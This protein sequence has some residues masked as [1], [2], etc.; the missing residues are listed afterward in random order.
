[1]FGPPEEVLVTEASSGA[2]MSTRGNDHFLLVEVA[3]ALLASWWTPRTGAAPMNAS[4]SRLVSVSRS[5]GH[6]IHSFCATLIIPPPQTLLPS[7]IP[8][9]CWM[10]PILEIRVFGLG[11]KTG[12]SFV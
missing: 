2:R 1:M 6:G 11:T 9:G 8:V 3:M 7:C 12:E 4:P 5:I 10:I